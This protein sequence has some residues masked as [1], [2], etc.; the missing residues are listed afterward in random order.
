MV[1][2]PE[3]F[4]DAIL[5]GKEVSDLKDKGNNRM[6]DG[7]LKR[8]LANEYPWLKTEY[9]NTSGYIHLSEQHFL[10]VIHSIDDKG[11]MRFYIGPDDKLI[12][13]ESYLGATETMIA[14]TH[15]LLTYLV[16]WSANRYG[17][18]NQVTE[19]S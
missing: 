5:S 14:V 18:P 4:A 6:T 2:D 8:E 3:Q 7:Y 19:S 16:N 13:V 9:K 11:K 17:G 1:E 10:N 15:A 12:K